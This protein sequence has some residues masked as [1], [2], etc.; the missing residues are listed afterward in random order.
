[1]EDCF[2]TF[3]DAKFQNTSL[4]ETWRAWIFQVCTEW[5]YFDT[6]PPD[7][8]QPRIVSRL[9]T[10]AYQSR[11]CQQAYP[12]GKHFVVPSFPNVTAVNALG[13]FSIVADRLA[14]IDGEVDPWRPDTPHSQYAE[15]RE[16][17]LI[18]PFK[19]I[20]NGVHHYDEYGLR[21]LEDEPEEIRKVHEE[22]IV[23]TMEWMKHWITGERRD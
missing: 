8:N 18:R 15:E 23:F 20:P 22:M 3:D 4:S 14:I 17:T 7:Q 2:G 6:A 9:L 21:N 11:I 1:M 19:L 10:L 12:P 13:D 16:D 5:G